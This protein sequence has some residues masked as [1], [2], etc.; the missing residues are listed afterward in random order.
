MS[1]NQAYSELLAILPASLK[2]EAWV[3]LTTRKRKPL[4]IS[5]VSGINP[6]VESFLQH[7]AQRYQ[8]NLLHHRR[9]RRI[10]D[11]STLTVNQTHMAESKE[12]QNAIDGELPLLQKRLL[13]HN[14]VTFGQLMQ[15]MTK[16]HEKQIEANRESRLAIEDLKMKVREAETILA[17]LASHR[18]AAIP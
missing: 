13:E 17:Y 1:F 11:W 5:E 7:E 15:D 2:R 6:E 18:S 4:S 9:M 8:K 14:R 16:T 10:K 12:M 3:R